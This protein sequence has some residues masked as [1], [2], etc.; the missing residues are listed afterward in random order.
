[1]AEEVGRP[2]IAGNTQMEFTNTMLN[3]RKLRQSVKN[4]LDKCTIVSIFP[5]VIDEDKYTIQ[6]GKFHIEKGT[7]E[8]PSILVIGGSSWWKDFDPDQDPLEMPRSSVEVA[9]AVI[10]DYCNS[11]VGVIPGSAS[12]GLFF[13]TGEK[14]LLEIKTNYREELKKADEKQNQWYQILVRLADSLWARGNGNPLVIMDDMRLAAKSLHLD[15]KPWLKDF[16][17]IQKVPCKFCGNLKDPS[18]PICGVCRAVDT[19]H[20]LGKEVKFA[21]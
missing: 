6:P 15:D 13:V 9:N 18:Y 4:P 2:I 17:A 3:R 1:M 7:L 16:Q 11:M 19:S 10:T 20:P 14:K 8:N 21:V 12:P 5:K